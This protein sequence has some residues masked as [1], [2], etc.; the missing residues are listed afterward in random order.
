VVE[1]LPEVIEASALFSSSV[2]NGAAFP[3]LHLLAADAR[4]YVR[5]S[6]QTYDVIVSDNFHP[7][8]SGS[9]SLYT[10]E[11]FQAVRQRL[12]KDGVFCQWLPLHQ[13]D[14]ATLRSIV[15][16]FLR[17]YPRAFSLIASGSLQT[18]VLGLVG[19]RDAGRFDLDALRGRL[20]HV[21]L[22]AQL[23]SIG[24]EDEFAVLGSFIAGPE[25]LGRFAGS[26]R[27]N[28]DD[29]PV[30]AYLAPRVTYAPDSRP[31]DRLIAVL[32]QLSLEPE[33]LVLPV[34]DASWPR[35]LAAYWTARNRFIESG[36]DVRPSSR[37]EDVLAQVQE[38]LLSVLRISPEFRPAYDPLL[39][40][41]TALARSDADGAQRLVTELIRAQ[42]A[43]TEATQL[44]ARLS[45]RRS[46]TSSTA[47]P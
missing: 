10:V 19:R 35:R 46:S 14:V 1:L 18:P 40:M 34:A 8:R 28:T 16:A 4:R 38:P 13:L 27:V 7:A 47:Q 17:A 39:S 5:A 12:A 42:P 25:S 45:V 32:Q 30:V 31:G 6:Q 41:A 43:R 11:H 23:A 36:R 2:A 9:G 29:R 15:A 37:V 22:P 24:L 26:A 33:Q 3:R 44:L 21:A 20:A